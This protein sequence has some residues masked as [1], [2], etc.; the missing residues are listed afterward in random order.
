MG[1]G[2][3]HTAMDATRYPPMP[4]RIR[5]P[6]HPFG[7]TSRQW[8]IV[9]SSA[10]GPSAV[11]NAERHLADHLGNGLQVRLFD[12]GTAALLAVLRAARLREAGEVLVPAFICPSVVEA[13]L[14]ARLR[15]VLFDSRLTADPSPESL[16]RQITMHAAAAILPDYYGRMSTTFADCERIARKNNLFVIA[17][18]AQS[19]GCRSADVCS[20]GRGDATILSFGRT[21]PL[22]AWS[23]GAVVTRASAPLA[24]SLEVSPSVDDTVQRSA[25]ESMHRDAK[26]RRLPAIFNP[27]LEATGAL[28]KL[29][30]DVTSVLARQT[31]VAD[32]L[33]PAQISCLA[34][35]LLSSQLDSF[36]QRLARWA[37]N[38]ELMRDQL[39]GCPGLTL[40]AGHAPHSYP[41]HFP[42]LVKPRIRFALAAHLSRQGIQ[43][44]WFHYPL[45]RMSPYQ[46]LSRDQLPGAE[47]LW[48]RVL[49][50]PCRDISE[51]SLLFVAAAMRDFMS[52]EV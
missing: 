12:S 43:T 46:T 22:N 42:V 18:A 52:R 36:P 39:S 40:P 41:V 24:E 48:R 33:V 38:A 47:E 28:R 3:T 5:V 51:R 1:S 16:E 45:H 26:L 2:K 20:A 37:R 15:P 25:I 6:V 9:R 19:F 35:S 7:W 11:E 8:Q 4:R 10:R 49:C 34:A 44:T 23:G 17:D 21:K 29:E 31:G 30:T 13:V 50:I 14:A 32:K 27:M